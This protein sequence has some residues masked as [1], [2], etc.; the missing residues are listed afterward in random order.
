MIIEKWYTEDTPRVEVDIEEV[1]NGVGG[2][3]G[4]S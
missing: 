4:F 1:G 3:E 2:M